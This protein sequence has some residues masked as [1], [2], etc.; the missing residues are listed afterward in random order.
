VKQK[1]N[2]SENIL[3]RKILADFRETNL[4]TGSF[5]ENMTGAKAQSTLEIFFRFCKKCFC[6][7]NSGSFPKKISRK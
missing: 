2:F 7:R 6:Y 1:D 4:F 5:R 3:Y